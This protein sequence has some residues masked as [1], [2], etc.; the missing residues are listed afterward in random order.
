MTENVIQKQSRHALALIGWLTLCFAVAGISGAFSAKAI[1][2]WYAS[3]VKPSFNPPNQVFGPVW[4]VLYAMMAVSV[5]MVW[6]SPASRSRTRAL[7]LFCVQLALN[8]TWSSIFFVGHQIGAA[9]V[10]IVLLWLAILATMVVFL[11]VRRDAAWLMIPYLAWVS[12][13]GFLNWA[14]WKL[15]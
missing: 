11:A 1:P 15:N 9:L 3:L 13:A 8:F 10:E 7:V 12:F 4:T 6:K 2:T 5:W 14:I